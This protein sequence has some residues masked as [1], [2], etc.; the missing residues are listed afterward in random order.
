MDF[1]A[2]HVLENHRALM[3][4]L[5]NGCR[6]PQIQKSGSMFSPIFE[7]W[8]NFSTLLWIEFPVFDESISG[9]WFQTFFLFSTIYSIYGIILPIDFHIFQHGYCTTNQKASHGFFVQLSRNRI[10]SGSLLQASQGAVP[11]LAALQVHSLRCTSS[12]YGTP[13]LL[14]LI[15]A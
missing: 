11:Y 10:E 6:N 14:H 15:V 1:P 2:S 5:S 13:Y 12:K 4:Q 7:L 8:S 9:W 3:I